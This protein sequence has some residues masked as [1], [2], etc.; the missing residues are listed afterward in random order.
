M[1]SN[2]PK[3]T[4]E[5]SLQ[6]AVGFYVTTHSFANRQLTEL[7]PAA[8]E[9]VDNFLKAV[10]FGV[11]SSIK[12]WSPRYFHTGSS[13]AYA[14]IGSFILY[15]FLTDRPPIPD[16]VKDII[17]N[18][19]PSISGFGTGAVGGSALQRSMLRRVGF[20]SYVNFIPLLFT[21]NDVAIAID[22][23]VQRSPQLG[24]ALESFNNSVG[25]RAIEQ[26]ER[27]R[28]GEPPGFNA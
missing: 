1:V 26:L 8:E 13:N 20:P 15:P 6:P 9:K 25:Q 19:L 27:S 10:K 11:K 28:E 16:Q 24:S 3:L 12:R 14:T 7:T 2:L 23:G 5:A 22:N 17:S 18:N 21:V 4:A